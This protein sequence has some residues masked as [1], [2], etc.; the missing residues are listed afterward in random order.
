RLLVFQALAI[1]HAEN[2]SRHHQLVSAHWLI[3]GHLVGININYF[4]HPVGIRSARRG[5]KIHKW[6]A[7]DLHRRCEHIGSKR[8]DISPSGLFALVIHQ[9]LGPSEPV[10]VSH[11]LNRT[12]SIRNRLSW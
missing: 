2:I 4:D 9:P 10:S 3:S 7:T 5:H 6:L 8:Q 11:G 1:S 12:L